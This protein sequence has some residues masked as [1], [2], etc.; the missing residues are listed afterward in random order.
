MAPPTVPDG[1][2]LTTLEFK[3][4]QHLAEGLSYPQIA[5]KTGR[6]QG[7]V[8]HNAARAY[9]KLGVHGMPQAIARMG[10]EGWWDWQPAPPHQDPPSVPEQPSPLAAQY[11]FLAGYL[12]EFERS[13]WPHEPDTRSILGMKLALAAH[14]N[15]Q[16]GGRHG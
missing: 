11:P 6:A 14:R 12:A 16:R 4:L 1:C 7:T 13:R 5:E 8:R 3:T 15:Q 9:R 10:R 2:P